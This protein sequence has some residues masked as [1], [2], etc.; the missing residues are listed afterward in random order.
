MVSL[1]QLEK[2]MSTGQTA[3]AL[4]C[5]RPHAIALAQSGRL[6][7]VRTAC[8]WLYDPKGVAEFENDEGTGGK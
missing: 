1:K 2:W 3:R 6:R 8:G 7:A 4:G 5:S